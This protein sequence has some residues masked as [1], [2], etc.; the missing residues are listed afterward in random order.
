MLHGRSPS[1]GEVHPERFAEAIA[2]LRPDVL[3][4]QEVDRSQPRSGAVDFTAVAAAAMGAVESRFVAA[5]AGTPGV[6][7][8]A[9]TGDEQPDAAAYGIALLSR[10]P[11]RGWNVLRLP[12]L[13]VPMPVRS[14]H[15]RR[16]FVGR[17]EPRVAVTAEIDSPVGELAVTTTHLS[18]VPGWNTRQLG[19]LMR[20]LSR[21]SCPQLLMG[22]LNLSPEPVAR[23]VGWRSL[24]DAATFPASQPSLQLDHV[25]S[26]QLAAR[27]PGEGIE[28]NLSDHRALVAVV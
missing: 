6:V 27:E 14:P 15:A 23:R 20:A 1:D 16:W 2:R 10:Y 12:R 18:F 4:L 21:S 19:T 11:V 5:V 17:D 8:T 3:A 28:L 24:V 7:W 22:D 13:P 25:L 26:D 9:A